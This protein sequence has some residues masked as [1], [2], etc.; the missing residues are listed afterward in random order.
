MAT[1]MPV[2]NNRPGWRIVICGLALLFV[3]FPAI[4]NLPSHEPTVAPAATTEFAQLPASAGIKDTCPPV[5]LCTLAAV[6]QALPRLPIPPLP[7][8]TLVTL[9]LA[10]R[11]QPRVP[12]PHRDWWLPPDRRRA[13]LQVFLI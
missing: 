5:D 9:V 1:P 3:V 8:L 7:L 13:F 11:W 4:M 12:A 6:E 10:L 2:E